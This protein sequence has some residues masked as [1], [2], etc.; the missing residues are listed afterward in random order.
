MNADKKDNP[1]D[2]AIVNAFGE[3][4]SSRENWVQTEIDGFNPS[5]KCVVAFVSNAE[6]KFL[7]IAKGLPANFLD[8]EAGAVDDHELQW[9][10]DKIND[11]CY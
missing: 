10:V 1:I 7:T 11:T 3:T 4:S 6:G 8:T 5:V 9:K 2:R